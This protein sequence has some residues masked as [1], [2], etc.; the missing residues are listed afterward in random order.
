MEMSWIPVSLCLQLTDPL[1]QPEVPHCSDLC[2]VHRLIYVTLGPHH[3]PSRSRSSNPYFLED[4]HRSQVSLPCSQAIP[5]PDIID[6]VSQLSISSRVLS[7]SV[8]SW[9]VWRIFWRWL[10]WPANSAWEEETY[11]KFSCSTTPSRAG[12]GWKRFFPRKR[13]WFRLMN[14]RE[15][16]V[17]FLM[18]TYSRAM[19]GFPF[20]D[21]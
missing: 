2:E 4:S 17:E 21:L 8:F 7:R 3:H 15:E 20:P 19:V 5:S 10:A 1:L 11:S 9:M 6:F 16:T 12:S 18:Q 14:G 13:G